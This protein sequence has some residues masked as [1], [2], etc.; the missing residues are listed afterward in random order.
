N[1]KGL[2]RQEWIVMI[3]LIITTTISF[4]HIK[5]HS[6]LL[7]LIQESFSL[8]DSAAATMQTFSTITR[9]IAF[10]VM[11]LCGDFLPKK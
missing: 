10:V 9:G 6:G 3:T 8:T 1:F 4:Y 7:P 5:A 2:S 11:W